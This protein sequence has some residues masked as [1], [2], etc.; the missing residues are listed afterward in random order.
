MLFV[1][2]EKCGLVEK[3]NVKERNDGWGS[4]SNVCKCVGLGRKIVAHCVYMQLAYKRY[5]WEKKM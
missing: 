1:I 5:Q 4:R 2:G 3:R